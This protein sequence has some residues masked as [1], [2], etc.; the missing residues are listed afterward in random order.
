[1]V[2]TTTEDP[3]Y[4]QQPFYTSTHFKMEPNGSKWSPRRARPTLRDGWPGNRPKA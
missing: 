1:M 4:L 2:I 3:K